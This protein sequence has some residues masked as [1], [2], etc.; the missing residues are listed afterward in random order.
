MPPL[1]PIVF[2]FLIVAATVWGAISRSNEPDPHLHIGDSVATDLAM[3]ATATFD[4]F[5]AAA[6]ALR[7]CIGAPRLEAAVELDDLATYD[8]PSATIH[9]RVPATAPSLRGSLVHELGHHLEVA[10]SS[11]VDV[12]PA[13]VAAQGAAETP[14]FVGVAWEDRPSEQFAEAVVEVVLGRRS[15]SQLRLR[16]TPEAVALVARWLEV[17]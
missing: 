11:H 3:L 16:L 15:R 7:H 8:Q 13:F 9:V 1:R 14:W 10:C 5:V 2:V 17:G 12:R 6:P 4:E